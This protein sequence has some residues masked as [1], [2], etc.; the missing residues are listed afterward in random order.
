MSTPRYE[1]RIAVELA[2]KKKALSVVQISAATGLSQPC[3]KAVLDVLRAEELVHVPTW[4]VAGRSYRRVACYRSGPG[5][6]AP[7]PPNMTPEENRERHKEYRRKTKLKAEAH[8]E[9]K[10]RERIAAELARP[11]FRDPFTTALFG[12]YEVRA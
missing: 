7:K 10:R 6:D 3:I 1:N 2:I 9:K 4:R 8:A 12:T 5:E 11:A